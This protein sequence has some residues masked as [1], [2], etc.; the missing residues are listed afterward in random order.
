MEW[1]RELEK[2]FFTTSLPGTV[3]REV[4]LPVL[5]YKYFGFIWQFRCYTIIHELYL[6]VLS[7]CNHRKSTKEGDSIVRFR[8]LVHHVQKERFMTGEWN[9]LLHRY[10]FG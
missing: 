8:R 6:F 4:P 3:L 1:L 7:Q 5:Y 10:K 2:G 9:S